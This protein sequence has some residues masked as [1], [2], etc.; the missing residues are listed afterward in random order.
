MAI[1]VSPLLLKRAGK[2]LT[3]ALSKTRW[4]FVEV[5]HKLQFNYVKV[6]KENRIR[7]DG[8]GFKFTMT[9]LSSGR[10]DIAAQALGIAAGA[11]ELALKYSM[12]RKAF[13]TEICNHQAVSN[14]LADMLTEI[15]ARYSWSLI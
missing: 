13:G 8:F 14:K 9:T 5:M 1:I 15:E 2:V 10:I 7:K 12:E 3:L 4:I 11:Y 6:P